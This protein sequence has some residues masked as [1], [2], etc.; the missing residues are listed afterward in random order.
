MKFYSNI[1]DFVFNPSVFFSYRLNE[2][3]TRSLL[4]L[5]GISLFL[6]F[7]LALVSFLNGYLFDPY[8]PY[9]YSLPFDYLRVGLFNILLTLAMAFITHFIILAKK[10][11]EITKSIQV[12]CYAQTPVL[13]AYFMVNMFPYLLTFS[14]GISG[15]INLSSFFLEH[16]FPVWILFVQILFLLFPLLQLIGIILMLYII[17]GGFK[18]IYSLHFSYLLPIFILIVMMTEIYRG[19]PIFHLIATYLL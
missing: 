8:N 18:V 15:I 1:K 4:Y 12:F 11:D 14:L 17:N 2:N 7:V 3:W 9:S 5:I 19:F 13:I 10:T 16:L 6:S